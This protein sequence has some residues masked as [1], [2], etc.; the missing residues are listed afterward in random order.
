MQ[1]SVTTRPSQ[2]ASN[3]W[4]TPDMTRSSI[5]YFP[6]LDGFRGISV[7]L[8]F[9]SHS[10][11]VALGGLGVLGVQMFFV[12]SGFLITSLLVH[13]WDATRSIR[14]SHFY[15]RRALRLL[16]AL[17]LLLAAVVVYSTLVLPEGVRGP[18]YEAATAALLYVYNWALIFGWI[19]AN[20]L[21]I[22]CW[23]L[24]VEEHFYLLWPA[25]IVLLLRLR[26]NRLLWVVA[27]AMIAAE[28]NR[29]RL[30]HG[31][32]SSLRDLIGSDV[33]AGTLLVGCTLA[34]ARHQGR[35]PQRAPWLLVTRSVAAVAGAGCL[36]AALTIGVE[37]HAWAGF[38]LG[39][40]VP[41]G[42]GLCLVATVTSG[43]TRW[44]H[45]LASRSLVWVGRRSYGIYLWHVPV[46]AALAANVAW[47]LWIMALV[48]AA[49]TFLIAAA[50]FRWVEQPFL[51]MKGRY[52]PMPP[53][54]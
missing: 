43:G 13:E 12:L 8:V 38:V 7:L 46:N 6:S 33:H 35:L 17:V 14:L 19:S 25:L 30:V 23:T 10:F 48:G 54:P 47:P 51:R 50:S 42:I 41:L 18:Q 11:V 39:T 9:A 34:V 31:G 15:M 53:A 49:L 52:S 27:A 36:T 3:R 45:V 1:E 37:E 28:L 4:Q 2:S 44:G 32:A 5:G 22:H 20:N 24:A 29:L 40:L 21:L 16:P 26:G